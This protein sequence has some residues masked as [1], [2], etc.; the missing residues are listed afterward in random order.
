MPPIIETHALSFQYGKQRI[1]KDISLSVPENSIYGFLG[2]NGAGKSTTIKVL[3]GL[4]R[5]PEKTAF[6]F[7][8]DIHRKRIDILSRTGN[9][10]ETPSLYGHLTAFD[11]L[12]IMRTLYPRAKSRIDE[13]LEL[14]GLRHAAQKKVKHFS[15]GMKQRLGIGQALFHDPDLLVLDEPVNGL[16]PSGIHEIRQLLLRLQANGKT[17]F[18][19]SHLLAE[20][21]KTCSHLGIIKDGSVLFQGKMEDLQSSNRRLVKLKTNDP[22]KGLELLPE[23]LKKQA[24][25]EDHF[26]QVDV[27]D[28]EHFQQMIQQLIQGGI[29]LYDIERSTPSLESLFMDLTK[30]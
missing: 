11:N 8:Q 29:A 1:L 5:V 13:V 15:M 21:E 18:I 4:L 6:L 23:N 17:V 10:I 27:P 22:K 30:N 25:I 16:D 20:I 2:P 12:K 24:N 7:G 19:S 28:D 9:L 3:L 14:V 26:L